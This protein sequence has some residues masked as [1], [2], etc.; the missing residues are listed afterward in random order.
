MTLRSVL[1]YTISAMSMFFIIGSCGIY[2]TRAPLQP[3]FAQTLGSDNLQFTGF[4]TEVEFQ[5]YVLWYRESS[6]GI[7]RICAFQQTIPFPTLTASTFP[8]PMTGAERFIVPINDLYPQDDFSRSFFELNVDFRSHFY[9]AV[10]AAGS[11]QVTSENLWSEQ[12][13]FGLWP[14]TVQ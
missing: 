8:L 2:T 1:A 14:T 6:T 11:D 4:N 7:Y 3:P 13:E 9:F 12:I 10:S 5:G